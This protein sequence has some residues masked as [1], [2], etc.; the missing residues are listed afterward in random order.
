M[1]FSRFQEAEKLS[2]FVRNISCNVK[3]LLSGLLL[4]FQKDRMIFWT[5]LTIVVLLDWFLQP[6]EMDKGFSCPIY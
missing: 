3:Q 1:V 4:C 2:V 5:M 6:E